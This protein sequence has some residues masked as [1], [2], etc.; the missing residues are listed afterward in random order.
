EE[1]PQLILMD[2]IMPG[3]NG[4]Q[5]TRRL[6]RDERTRNI[7]VIM[8]SS[9]DSETD[10]AWGMRQGAKDYLT[11]PVDGHTLLNAISGA[12]AA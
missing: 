2:I 6:S 10:R 4:Y 3:M 8:V 11:K 7:P 12:M 1:K 9:R 5:A